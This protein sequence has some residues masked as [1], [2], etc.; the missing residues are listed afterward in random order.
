VE[1]LREMTESRSID[2]HNRTVPEAIR[3]FVRFHNACVRS[4]YRGRIEVIHGYGSTGAGGVIRKKLR[5]YLAAHEECFGSFLA[6]DGL[7]NPG[8]TIVYPKKLLPASP[9][10]AGAMPLL[11]A[12]Q[13]A[14][15]KYCATPKARERILIKL[16]GRFGDR[17]LSAEIRT[18]V[19]CGA[20]EE[21][22]ASDGKL[23]LKTR[24]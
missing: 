17:V 11:N 23:Q 20:L 1:A 15:R 8:V 24:S 9:G 21:I 14:I 13:E 6:G 4:N 19:N 16:R 5:E 10:G 7:G 12:A 2:L 3:E 18:M 22:Q